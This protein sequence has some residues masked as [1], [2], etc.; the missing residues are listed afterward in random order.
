MIKHL[1]IKSLLDVGCGRGISTSWFITHGLQYV[2]C[3][4]GSHDAIQQS[5][6]PQIKHISNRTTYE[7][8]EHDFSRGPWWPSRTVVREFEALIHQYLAIPIYRLSSILLFS[9]LQDVV[10]CVEVHIL[11]QKLTIR[12]LLLNL[13]CLSSFLLS[14]T[15]D[16][17]FTEHVG[18]NFQPNYITAWRKAALI[19]M[20][21]SRVGG[22]HHVEVHEQAWWVDKMESL[23]FVFMSRLTDKMRAKAMEDKFRRDLTSSMNKSDEKS[24]NVGQHIWGTLLV[25]LWFHY[26][27]LYNYCCRTLLTFALP[28]IMLICLQR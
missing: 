13:T 27:C 8:V 7:I 19:F 17:Q 11:Q 2:L 4:E 15:F 10:W 12:S 23:G 5:L 26:L 3:V 25:M 1:G 9:A 21:H 24:F 20:T 28:W 14:L 22:W 6:I 18:R 16:D